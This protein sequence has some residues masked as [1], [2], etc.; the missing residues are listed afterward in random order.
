MIPQ[1]MA[2]AGLISLASNS[3]PID[4]ASLEI[5]PYDA[6]MAKAEDFLQDIEDQAPEADQ[7]QED[8]NSQDPGQE[9]PLAE[10]IVTNPAPFIPEQEIAQGFND[11]AGPDANVDGHYVGEG[12]A[13]FSVKGI[14]VVNKEYALPPGYH[15]LADQGDGP[16][17]VLLP[18]AKQAYE[19]MRAAAA[20]EGIYFDMVSGFRSAS[21]QDQLFQSYAAR[22]GTDRAS[23]F[24]ARGG[25]SEHQTGLAMDVAA[26]GDQATLL[27]P[28]FG[29]TPAGQWLAQHSWE[30]GFILRYLQGKEAITGYQYEPWHFRY[31][32]KEM[33]AHIG[34]NPTQTLEE[35]LGL[36]QTTPAETDP[37]GP[38]QV[39][40][41]GK[42]YDRTDHLFHFPDDLAPSPDGTLPSGFDNRLYL[43]DEEIAKAQSRRIPFVIRDQGLLVPFEDGWRLYL[44]RESTPSQDQETSDLPSLSPTDSS[45]TS[46]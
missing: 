35:A 38:A 23:V 14:L 5:P 46:N 11:V 44:Q 30:Y 6:V 1:W 9:A 39:Y 12:Q 26:S 8:P 45:M 43:T 17:Q 25:Q 22:F 19:E 27:Q 10:E 41:R 4:T 24:S 2:L 28:S 42:I 21:Y 40:F 37:L 16:T 29:N 7:S 36:V 32:G 13:P 34:A 31:V 33:A 18:H 15:P 3:L 20:A